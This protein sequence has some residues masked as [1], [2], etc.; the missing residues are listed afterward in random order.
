MASLTGQQIQNSYQGL[1]KTEGNS[2]IGIGRTKITDG[3]GTNTGMFFWKQYGLAGVDNSYDTTQNPQWVIGNDNFSVF[4]T[5]LGASSTTQLTFGDNDEYATYYIQQNR[6]GSVTYFTA[7]EG[8]AHIF[9]GFNNNSPIRMNTYNSPNNS[10]NWFTGY[11]NSVSSLN[12]DSGT[13]DLTL[14]RA[15][16]ADLTVNIPTGGGGSGTDTKSLHNSRSIGV[17]LF[18]SP[19]T[20]WKMTH[21]TSGYSTQNYTIT[22]GN[23]FMVV[24]FTE[25]AGNTIDDLQFYVSTAQA[26]AT[27]NL[28]LY[29]AYKK[30]LASGQVVLDGEFVND[31]G[32]NIDCST[33]GFKTL[34]GLGL[35]LPSTEDSVYFILYRMENGTNVQLHGIAESQIINPNNAIFLSGTIAYRITTWQSGGAGSAPTYLDLDGMSPSTGGGLIRTFYTLS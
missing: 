26:G 15:D 3:V 34:T 29:K 22:S 5:P 11:Q 10:D 30:T 9:T 14:G 16:N 32:L 21:Q 6:F 28:H 33:T 12:F 20:S 27:V 4:N 17:S 18:G 25:E 24:P 8:Q 13:G 35:S 7:K 31:I 1:L 23:E 19:A 2:A